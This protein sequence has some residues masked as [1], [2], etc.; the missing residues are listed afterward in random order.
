MSE[1]L[2]AAGGGA[3]PPRRRRATRAAPPRLP[4]GATGSQRAS[5]SRATARRSCAAATPGVWVVGF[6]PNGFGVLE[7]EEG[8]DRG[9]TQARAAA[10]T[11]GVSVHADGAFGRGRGVA[12]Y[13][14]G[15][16]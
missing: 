8:Q 1:H 3:A 13:G 9:Q 14:A 12:V 4:R 11:S 10:R 2:R 7:G 16:P 15:R 5:R 6:V